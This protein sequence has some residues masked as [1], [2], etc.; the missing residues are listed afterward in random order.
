MRIV[1]IGFISILLISCSQRVI[2]VPIVTEK[3]TKNILALG[4]SLTI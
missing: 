4:D 1:L 3:T 2:D